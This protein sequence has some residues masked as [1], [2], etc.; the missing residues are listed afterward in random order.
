MNFYSY[1]TIYFIYTNYIMKKI[2]T[3]QQINEEV[4]PNGLKVTQSAQKETKKESDAYYKSVQKKV[5]SVYGNK[6]KSDVEPIK[7]NYTD[8]EKEVHDQMET[9]NGLE[10]TEY[11]T[12]PN[13]TFKDRAKKAITG[14]STM[15]NKATSGKWNPETGEGNGNTEPVWGASSENFGEEL[16]DRVKKSKEKRDK[17]GLNYVALGDDME[18]KSKPNQNKSLAF[19]ST[20]KNMNYTHYAVVNGKIVEGFDLTDKSREDIKLQLESLVLEPIKAVLK[21][22]VSKNDVKLYTSRGLAKIGLNEEVE[23]DWVQL[24]EEETDDS[25][26]Y[27]IHKKSNTVVESF[28]F[29]DFKKDEIMERVRKALKE[30]FVDI[31]PTEIKI[32]SKNNALKE[33]IDLNSKYIIRES[34]IK[35]LKFKNSFNGFKKAETLIPE[36]YKVDGKKFEMTDGNETYLVRWEGTLN[37]GT[38][39]VLSEENKEAINESINK[40]KHLMAF[41]S[42]ECET[43]KG[44]DRVFESQ[45]FELNLQKAKRFITESQ[46]KEK[47]LMTE[48]V[49]EKPIKE[50][51]K[52]QKLGFDPIVESVATL[53]KAKY[54]VEGKSYEGVEYHITIKE[55]E[56]PTDVII[57]RIIEENKNKKPADRIIE[58]KFTN[59]KGE[60]IK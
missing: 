31:K 16:L 30:S 4:S 55:S 54:I 44:K 38:A 52:A 25:T 51:F 15:G 18:M 47:S 9:L 60:I 46:E 24:K 53:T 26:H 49:A 20:N 3:K 48:S 42:L 27:M 41:N 57:G 19:E 6:G 2:V 10:M 32:V 11:S 35:R 45:L 50:K 13:D 5:D 59:E 17:A 37:E 22:E 23:S 43:S 40:M 28:N 1:P 29:K 21:E 8:A 7:H 58:F 12:E 33:G 39:V 36:S 56:L 34:K 14:D